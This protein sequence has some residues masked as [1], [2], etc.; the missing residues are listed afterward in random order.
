MRRFW[1][2]VGLVIIGWCWW[3]KAPPAFMVFAVWVWLR[4]YGLPVAE[5]CVTGTE[6]VKA[7]GFMAVHRLQTQVRSWNG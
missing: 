1:G 3:T 4:L 5:Y 2:S 7:I 6:R